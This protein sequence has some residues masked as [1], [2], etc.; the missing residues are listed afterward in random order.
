[1]ECED[2][3]SGFATLLP[4]AKVVFVPT[5]ECSEARLPILEAMAGGRAVITTGQAAQGLAFSPSYDLWI[6]DQPDNFATG[7]LRL[8]SD[9]DFREELG[10]H[11]AEAVERQHGRE[12]VSALVDALLDS[13]V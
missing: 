5:R 13:F 10:T 6:A 11:G 1:M 7:L 4:L 12:R 9:A 8:L 2:D 3:A